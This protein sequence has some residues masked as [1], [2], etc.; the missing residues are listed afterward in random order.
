MAALMSTVMA[1]SDKLAEYI[2]SCRE[3]GIA[4]DP[5]DINRSG[6]GFTFVGDKMYFGLLAIKNAGSGLADRLILERQKNGDFKS[7]QDFCERVEGRELNKKALENI[8][9]FRSRFRIAS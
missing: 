1:S 6:K 3:H 7:L 8:V 5:P 9:H 2:S 4:V